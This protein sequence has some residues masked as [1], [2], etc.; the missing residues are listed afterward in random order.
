MPRGTPPASHTPRVAPQAGPASR[1]TRSA[2]VPPPRAPGSALPPRRGAGG[3]PSRSRPARKTR[4]WP[5]LGTRWRRWLLT[6]GIALLVLGAVLLTRAHP[7]GVAAPGG[8]VLPG[9]TASSAPTLE[10]TRARP[11]APTATSTPLALARSPTEVTAAFLAAYFTWASG[12]E[13]ATYVGGWQPAVDPAALAL[14]I[15]NAPR[16]LLDG[17]ADAAATAPAPV[18][19][20]LPPG[21]SGQIQ[22]RVTWDIA[23]LP[24]GGELARWQPRRIQATVALL[25]LAGAGWRVAG[26]TWT[27]TIPT[28]GN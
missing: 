25:S 17:G 4:H 23:V 14:L 10:P 5:P 21:T 20:A 9:V 28:G 6:G 12:E 27:S 8:A 3:H 7:A 24:A 16:L 2:R 18:V 15:R 11:P 1:L 19:G 22:V 26:L 13:D